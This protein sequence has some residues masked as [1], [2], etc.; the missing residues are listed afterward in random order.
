MNKAKKIFKQIDPSSII[1]LA[2][3]TFFLS[4]IIPSISY[5]KDF[6]GIH[7]TIKF[8]YSSLQQG[9][10]FL[11]TTTI[12]STLIYDSWRKVQVGIKVADPAEKIGKVFIFTILLMLILVVTLYSK[13]TTGVKLPFFGVLVEVGLFAVA[14]LYNSHSIWVL[15]HIEEYSSDFAEKTEKETVA[16]AEESLEP[17]KNS[18]N[19]EKKV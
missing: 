12:M 15:N 1:F 14:I 7:S 16:V 13:V 4:Y 3:S 2:F 5:G 11:P 6:Q 18:K 17:V 8:I 19:G 10:L 9:S